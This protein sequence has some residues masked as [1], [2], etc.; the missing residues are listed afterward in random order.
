[1]VF[2]PEEINSTS[3]K[4]P[5]FAPPTQGDINIAMNSRRVLTFY[6]TITYYNAHGLTAIQ[7]WCIDLN[8]FSGK[9]P[10]DRQGFKTSLSEPFL[11]P[12]NSK[13]VLRR[14]AVERGK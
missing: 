7:T 6:A 4:R 2:R 1:M 9:G 8:R 12:F 14:Q 3:R 5:V 11:L 13:T 10:A